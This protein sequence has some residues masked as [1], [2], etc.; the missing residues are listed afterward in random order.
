M[1]HH[2]LTVTI[3]IIDNYY[4]LVF[5]DLCEYNEVMYCKVTLHSSLQP[6]C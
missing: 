3:I 1:Y 5:D 6:T 2:G 4:K